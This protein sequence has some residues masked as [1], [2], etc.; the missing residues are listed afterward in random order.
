M[1]SDASCSRG[2][3]FL[4]RRDLSFIFGYVVGINMNFIQKKLLVQKFKGSVLISHQS[5]FLNYFW[6]KKRTAGF[7]FA[8]RAVG[9][10]GPPIVNTLICLVPYPE[11]PLESREIYITPRKTTIDGVAR[12]VRGMQS[13]WN[14]LKISSPPLQWHPNYAPMVYTHQQA[15]STAVC[16]LSAPIDASTVHKMTIRQQNND[17]LVQK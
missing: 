11:P 10:A 6:W 12:Q 1:I 3:N 8:I 9:L 5:R 4:T 2:C 13:I 17:F 15:R 7:V 14:F 16:S